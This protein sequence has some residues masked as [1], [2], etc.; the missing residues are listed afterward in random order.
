MAIA[1]CA[2]E[3]EL[4]SS[5]R[6]KNG[7]CST[8]G[9]HDVETPENILKYPILLFNFFTSPYAAPRKRKSSVQ[10]WMWVTGLFICAS[11]FYNPHHI[12]FPMTD[13]FLNIMIQISEKPCMRSY[14]FKNITARSA[15]SYFVHNILVF[16]PSSQDL[17][18]FCLLHFNG[19]RALLT[20]I[21]PKLSRQI[22]APRSF[23]IR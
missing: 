5:R 3:I 23:M 15:K 6:S 16:P 4:L 21:S 22:V 19:R 14:I 7:T 13:F 8:V 1:L 20:T 9:P 12:S 2:L 18:W 11:I 10:H 17:I